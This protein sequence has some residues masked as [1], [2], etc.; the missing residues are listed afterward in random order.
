VELSTTREATHQLQVTKDRSYKQDAEIR[1]EK[2]Y[3]HS[4]VQFALCVP[5][6]IGTVL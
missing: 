4:I 1:Y 6:I 2:V 3:S 5:V